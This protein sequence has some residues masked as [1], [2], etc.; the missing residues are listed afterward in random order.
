MIPINGG[1][2]SQ[3]IVL[4]VPYL[5]SDV[6]QNAN[7]S[8]GVNT[9]LRELTD[10]ARGKYSDSPLIM[11][12]HMYAKDADIA[13]SDASE[14]IVIGG[15]EEVNMHGWDEHPQVAR[16]PCRLQKKITIMG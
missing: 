9:I 14:K 6:V 7:Y 2:G 10:R 3:A 13:K 1:D 11:M 15:Q 16:A 8:D 12:A 5:R 4:T